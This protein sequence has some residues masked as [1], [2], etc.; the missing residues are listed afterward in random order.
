[1]WLAGCV[2]ARL[3]VFV[4]E[5][6]VEQ[7]GRPF[8]AAIPVESLGIVSYS[9]VRCLVFD[10]VTVF[11]PRER[12][13]LVEVDLRGNF[14]WLERTIVVSSEKPEYLIR[15]RKTFEFVLAGVLEGVSVDRHLG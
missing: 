14:V 15:D 7:G 13:T 4:T 5:L 8:V 11:Q 6:L 3:L 1:M 2:I 12:S 9:L 10:H